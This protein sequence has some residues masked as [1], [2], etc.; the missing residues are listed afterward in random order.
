VRARISYL[1]WNALR[2]IF[3]LFDIALFAVPRDAGVIVVEDINH[4]TVHMPVNMRTEEGQGASRLTLATHLAMS[5]QKVARRMM[6][7]AEELIDN[8]DL[9]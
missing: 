6:A 8:A 2:R 5:D 9:S 1:A 4:M 7:K 3:T